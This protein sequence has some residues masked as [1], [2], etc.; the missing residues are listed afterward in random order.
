MTDAPFLNARALAPSAVAV[1]AAEIAHPLIDT[2]VRAVNN[3]E[4]LEFEGAEWAAIG[5]RPKV[6]RTGDGRAIRAAVEVDNAGREMLAWVERAG[7]GAGGA[8]RLLRI[9]LTDPPELE[10]EVTLDIESISAD[11]YVLNARLGFEAM[12]R[13]AAVAL[14]MD[15][16]R[17]PGLF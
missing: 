7:G 16:E 10:W 5:F 17:A 12:L 14:R 8:I 1:H 3:R 9:L 6:E 13:R 4:P 11:H 15:P 2:P